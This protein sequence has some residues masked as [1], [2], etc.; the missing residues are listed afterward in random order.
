[1][2]KVGGDSE[3]RTA[4]YT[5]VHEDSSTESTNKFLAEVGF[6]KFIII[7]ILGFHLTGCMVGPNFHSPL[8]PRLPRYTETPM[9]HKTVSMPSLGQ[10]G[11]AQTFINGQNIPAEWWYLFHSKEINQLIEAGLANNPNLAS[12]YA[13]LRGAQEALNAQIGNS[14]FPAFN[15]ALSG[16]RQRFSDSSIGSTPGSSV[17]NLFNATVNV[18]YTLDVFGG[19]RRQIEQFRAQVD[20]QQFQLIAAYLTLTSNIVATAVTTASLQEQIEATRELLKSERYQ[21]HILEKQWE[22]GG[23]AKKY[24]INTTNISRTN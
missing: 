1:M 7:L 11:K 6:G 23:I 21:L 8:S 3:H 17:F 18:A 10:A 4:V 19:A 14:L 22:L 15:G 13:A 16:Q 20:Y 24:G 12:A 2:R 9:P 5:D